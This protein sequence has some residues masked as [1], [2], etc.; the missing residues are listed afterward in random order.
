MSVCLSALKREAPLG[1]VPQQWKSNGVCV[2]ACEVD[3]CCHLRTGQK[4]QGL[5]A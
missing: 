5:A 2:R 3:V 1:A 4:T